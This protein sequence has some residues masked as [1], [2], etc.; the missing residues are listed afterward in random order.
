VTGTGSAVLAVSD[1]ARAGY[2]QRD[3]ASATTPVV[4]VEQN[5]TVDANHALLVTQE[6]TGS[7][8]SVIGGAANTGA[9][10][11]AAQFGNGWVGRITRDVST[12]DEPVVLASQLNASDT[13]PAIMGVAVGS[14]AAIEGSSSGNGGAAR[15]TRNVATGSVPVVAAVQ[16]HAS[17]NIAVISATNDGTGSSAHGV[18]GTSTGGTGVYGTSVGGGAAGRFDRN[19]TG[20]GDPVLDVDQ[21][22]GS[23]ANSALRINQATATSYII[24]AKSGSDNRLTITGKGH[25]RINADDGGT[26][27]LIDSEDASDNPVLHT[28]QVDQ[29]NLTY[30]DTFSGTAGEGSQ[31]AFR[32]SR[33]T[34][35]S[36]SDVASGDQV[37][38]IMWRAMSTSFTQRAGIICVVDGTVSGSSVPMRI[39][40]HTGVTAMAETMRLDSDGDVSIGTLATPTARLDVKN[41]SATL[42]TARFNQASTADVIVAEDNGTAIW[43]V[44]D[45]GT[46]DSSGCGE[47]QATRTVTASATVAQD[48]R[49]IFCDTATATGNIVL[50][51]PTPIAG[52]RLTIVDI[53]DNAGTNRVI[54]S[55]GTGVAIDVTAANTNK[56]VLTANGESVEV[57]AASTT[58]WWTLLTPRVP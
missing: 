14:G 3:S 48:D 30:L 11:N 49:I 12:G 2:F 10:F 39:E 33:G 6:G 40:F 52:R 29:N 42:P 25:A 46:V 36:E 20:G 22:H 28:R 37:G 51:M 44:K 41:S 19:T 54:L 32:R 35:L 18:V 26:G 45:G 15:F 8:I 31:I 23:D 50:T 5:D 38:A 17:N 56:G 24:E 34:V 57:I 47:V 43:S 16:D 4:A 55:P 27:L 58:L 13:N 1:T 53:G 21:V 9:L 7:G